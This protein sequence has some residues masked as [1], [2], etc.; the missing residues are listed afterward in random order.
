[1]A[2][3][4]FS[5]RS[6]K[7]ES[8]LEV[9]LSF[10][11]EGEK[12]PI[13]IYA[14]SKLIAEKSYW[15][16]HNK[17]IQDPELKDIKN[18]LNAEIIKIQ[19]FVL[20][21]FD[22][23]PIKNINK[24]W[25]TK[26]LDRF[27]ASEEK[28]ESQL[29]TDLIAYME[30]YL[31][32]RKLEINETA[33]RR[34]KVVKRKIERLQLYLGKTIFINEVNEHF[35]NEYVKFCTK[36]HYS[37]NTQ[38]K[39]FAMVKTICLHARYNGLETHRQLDK[40]VLK[41]EESLNIYLTE[42]EIEKIEKVELPNEHLENA[43]DWLLLSCYTAQRISDFMHF[44]PEMIRIVGEK[45]LLEFR[46]QKTKK[47]MTIPFIKEAQT[48]LE[49]RN[50]TFPRPIS[51]QKYNDYIKIVCREAEITE[52]V[53]GKK[54]VNIRPEKKKPSKN[55]YRNVI[56]LF[57]KCDLISSHVGRRSFASNYYGKVPTSHL[58]NITGHSSE[59]MFLG[60]IKKSSKDLAIDAYDYFK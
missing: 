31:E 21:E 49:K 56:G 50:G 5:Y 57:E 33:K 6:T 17:N 45:K 48:I 38:Q 23:E 51:H 52:K 29:P 18:K 10:R 40:L 1:M 8:P 60:Y 2:A 43:R 47:L 42:Q 55:D 46:Q 59:K 30:F 14:R 54:R 16:R 34:T 19:K 37:I 39:E 25:L 12:N 27:Y 53:K 58:I 4:T 20:K 28:N 7:K 11:V 41:K 13:S 9:R 3:L 22:K 32:Q 26:S 35:K 15:K 44:T 24:K 36:N